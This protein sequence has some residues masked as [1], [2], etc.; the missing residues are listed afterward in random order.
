[1]KKANKD[2][3]IDTVTNTMDDIAEITAMANE[4]TDAINAVGISNADDDELERELEELKNEGK[5]LDI[6]RNPTLP[7]VPN[8]ELPSATKKSKAKDMT[9]A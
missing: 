1:M 5:M 3:D 6:N 9:L 4:I 8:D 2:L 7:E